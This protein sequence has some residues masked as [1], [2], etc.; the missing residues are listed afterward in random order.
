MHCGVA[1]LQQ[2]RGGLT[3]LTWHDTASISISA[4][5][6]TAGSIQLQAECGR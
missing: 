5:L 2:S 3:H 6:V 4:P 1:A